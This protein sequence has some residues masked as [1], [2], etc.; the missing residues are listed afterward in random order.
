MKPTILI[1]AGTALAGFFAAGILA[2]AQGTAFTYQGLLNDGA[3]PANGIYDLR[4]A[5]YDAP[6]DGTLIAGPLTNSATAMSNGLFTTGLDFGNQFPGADRWLEIGVRTNGTD[7]FTTLAPRQQLTPTPY[8]I[9]AGTVTGIVPSGGLAG[10]YSG[11]VT[12]NNPADAFAGNG[13]GLTNL[14]SAQLSGTVPDARLSPNVALRSGGNSFSGNQTIANGSV[15]IGTPA[16]ASVL[17]LKNSGDTQ[18]SIESSDAGGRR[19]TIQSSGVTGSTSRDASLQLVDRT[20]NVSRL[21]IGTNGNVGIGTTSP[22]GVLHVS[23][24]TVV[25]GLVTPSATAATNLLNLG[26]GTTADGFRNG[27][28]FYEA[29]GNMAMSLGYDGTGNANQNALRIYRTSGDPLFTF[30]ANGDIGIGTTNPVTALHIKN[31]GDTQISLESSDAGSHRWTLQSSGVT[32]DANL[33]ASFQVIDR[34]SGRARLLIATNGNVGIGTTKP[35]STLAVN[36]TVG[37]Q[38]VIVT[39]TVRHAFAAGASPDLIHPI[40]YG[41]VSSSGSIQWGTPNLSSVWNSSASRYEIT[42]DGESYSFISYTTVVTPVGLSLITP[43]TFSSSGKLLVSL[44]TSAG[45]RT[46]SDFGFVVYR[47][48]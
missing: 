48:D 24:S 45:T 9:T 3:N 5:I 38:D 41:N 46:Q 18:I 19:W 16:P 13:G 29:A 4:F 14:A 11:P 34:S 21:L 27:I 33:D 22:Q 20:L 8:A 23:G 31:A 17:H 30:Q 10:T 44:F 36:G 32:G 7:A 25:Q 42:I 12:F 43:V 2:S 47:A 1:L 37:A 28:S 39:N 15:G 26:S 35:A 40:A 6:G